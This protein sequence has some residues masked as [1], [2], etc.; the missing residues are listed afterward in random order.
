MYDDEQSDNNSVWNKKLF[1]ISM[2]SVDK[3]QGCQDEK[4]R[5]KEK[6]EYNGNILLIK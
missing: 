6:K 4:E 3:N 2:A 1:F 5:K